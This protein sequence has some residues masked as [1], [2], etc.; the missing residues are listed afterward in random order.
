MDTSPVQPPDTAPPGSGSPAADPWR[1]WAHKAVVVAGG[2]VLIGGLHVAKPVLV[3]VMLAMIFAL[4]LSI[5]VDMLTRRWL[6]RWLASALVVLALV[7]AVGGS[8][9]AVWDPAR[10]WL[11]TA[12]A[13]LRTLEAKLRPLTRF[14]AKVESVS[15]QAGHMAVPDTIPVETAAL[16]VREVSILDR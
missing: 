4:L 7:L 8:L 9:N 6:P 1:R 14:I 11:D 15:T 16:P 3:P 2:V 5:V 12:P 10:D 13:T